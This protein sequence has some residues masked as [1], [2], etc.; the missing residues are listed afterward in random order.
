MAGIAELLGELESLV[1]DHPLRE[2]LR[3]MLMLALYRSGRQADALGVYRDTR[4]VLAEELGIDP[5]PTLQALELAILNQ[6][7][8]LDVDKRR[9]QVDDR[10]RSS[11]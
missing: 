2:G 8:E 6:S 1:H 11:V 3:G 9:E 10:R 5:N 7:A 4:Q